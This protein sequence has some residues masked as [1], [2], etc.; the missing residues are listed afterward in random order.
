MDYGPILLVEIGFFWAFMYLQKVV[1]L[2]VSPSLLL[3]YFAVHC[4]Y[5]VQ[6]AFLHKGDMQIQITLN[7]LCMQLGLN[8]MQYVYVPCT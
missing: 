8:V 5:E 2:L 7:V 3:D 1:V 4:S 6:A